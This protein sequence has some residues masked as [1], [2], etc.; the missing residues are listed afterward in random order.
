MNV[1]HIPTLI[2]TLLTGCASPQLVLL[3]SE[4]DGQGAVAII[5]SHGTAGETIVD[6]VNS[7]TRLGRP[8]P[9]SEIIDPARLTPAERALLASLP[10]PPAR[11]I[12]YFAEGTTQ[13]TP[14]SLPMLAALR[15]EVALRPGAEVQVTGHTDTV[16]SAEDNDML[17]KRR[18]VEI[19]GVLA[20]Q[21]I[22]PALMTAVGRGERELREPTADNVA[23]AANRRVEVIVR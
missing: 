17:S 6:K 18:A 21:G 11:F 13:L 5:E 9:A 23:S 16:G 15:N 7:R 2:C 4:H 14:E 8:H 20:Q 10:A 3:P 12:L 22:E 19:V 1:R